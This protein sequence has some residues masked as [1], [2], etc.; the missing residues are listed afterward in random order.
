MCKSVWWKSNPTLSPVKSRVHHQYATD[1]NCFVFVLLTFVFVSCFCFLSV[2]FLRIKLLPTL[3]HLVHAYLYS[4]ANCIVPTIIADTRF[5]LVS[6]AYET[7]LDPT[8]VQSAIYGFETIKS[9]FRA[10]HFVTYC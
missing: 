4:L 10:T 3:Y 6:M 9:L 1:G 5:E 7:M 2:K 8:P